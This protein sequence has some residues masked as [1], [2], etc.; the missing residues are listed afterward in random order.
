MKL[1]VD[2]RRV[3]RD[4]R[5]T[6]RALR[7]FAEVSGRG[8]EKETKN[9]ARR[10]AVNLAFRTQPFG[11][12]QSAKQSGDMAVRRDIYRVF[13][14]PGEMYEEISERAG[15]NAA[16]GFYKIALQGRVGPVRK[17]LGSL[18]MSVNVRSTPDKSLHRAR[19][20]RR[21]RVADTGPDQLVL[22]GKNRDALERYVRRVQKRVGWAAAGWA[23]AAA[24][25]GSTRGIPKFKKRGSRGA[26]TARRTGGKKRPGYVLINT[27][28]YIRMVLPSGEQRKAL[29]REERT[30]REQAKIAISKARRKTGFKRGRRKAA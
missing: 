13:T 5:D 2:Q 23:A 18:G 22:G 21:G 7:R 8:I 10:L 29:K 17:F 25:I 30:L 19:R 12:R 3:D 6:S 26:G 1:K 15:K 24:K 4:V 16:K 28:D 9:S 20:D 14:T 11:D 27:V